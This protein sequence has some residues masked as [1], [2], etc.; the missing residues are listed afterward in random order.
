M[1]KRPVVFTTPFAPPDGITHLELLAAMDAKNRLAD[2]LKLL[3][4]T[5]FELGFVITVETAPL[6]PL[7]MRNYRMIGNVRA[8]R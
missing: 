3:L 7:A 8:A 2:Q 4:E 6:E 1:S 5:A